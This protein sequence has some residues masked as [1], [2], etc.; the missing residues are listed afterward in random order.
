MTVR[1][2][3]AVLCWREERWFNGES[4]GLCNEQHG[5][6]PSHVVSCSGTGHLTSSVSFLTQVYQRV[7]PNIM[8]GG[9]GKANL[10]GVASIP[11]RGKW[12]HS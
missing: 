10:D 5:S 11:F 3:A 8:I 4:A 6:G 9:G 2:C 12:K 7:S 1:S